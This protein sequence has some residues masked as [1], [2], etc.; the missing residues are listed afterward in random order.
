MST[1]LTIGHSDPR[2]PAI[3]RGAMTAL[4]K[5]WTAHT[6]KR[7]IADVRWAVAAA[8]ARLPGRTSCLARAVAAQAM[9][10]RRRVSTTLFYGAT[11]AP[12]R[13]LRAHA[14][15]Q[16]GD[17]AVVGQEAAPDYVVVAAYSAAAS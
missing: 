16:A 13:R 11:S 7:A 3:V 5:V 12:D 10:R 2:G 15:L 6:L 9:L 8:A 4:W 17:E 14:W 1:V